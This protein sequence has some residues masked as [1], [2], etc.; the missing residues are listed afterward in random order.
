MNIPSR[1]FFITFYFRNVLA[2]ASY[3]FN[4]INLFFKQLVDLHT[5]VEKVIKGKH[6]I[7]FFDILVQIQDY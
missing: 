7:R 4:A 1:Q 3:Y 5:A 2:I 6:T